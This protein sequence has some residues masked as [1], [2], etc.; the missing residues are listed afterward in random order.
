MGALGGKKTLQM[1]GEIGDGWFPA[2]N[3]I[4][5]FERGCKIIDESAK[6]NNRDPGQIEKIHDA[7]V[8]LTNGD[9][10]KERKSIDA[11][12]NI[13]FTLMSKPIMNELSEKGLISP[14][15]KERYSELSYQYIDPTD[16]GVKKAF[17][18]AKKIPPDTVAKYLTIGRNPAEIMDKLEPF[19]KAGAR[20]IVLNDVYSLSVTANSQDCQNFFRE[21][22]R[23]LEN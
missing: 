12:R 9:K 17:S 16:E 4:E 21:M 15:E 18:L 13:L 14:S 7:F 22:S 6:A 1:V 23:E 5:M 20:Q 11:F 3:S 10:E 2:I 8:V 19:V